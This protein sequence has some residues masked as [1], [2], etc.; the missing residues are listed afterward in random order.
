MLPPQL[1]KGRGNGLSKRLSDAKYEQGNMIDIGSTWIE[2][3]CTKCGY[4]VDA[5]LRDVELQSIVYCHCCK[6]S[7]KLIDEDASTNTAM[8]EI[9]SSFDD[10]ANSLKKLG[11]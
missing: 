1:S 8:K 2:V 9:Q 11:L 3:N 6:T 4:L 10:L 7:F 5:Q